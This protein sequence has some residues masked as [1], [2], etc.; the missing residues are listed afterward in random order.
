MR[1]RTNVI[2]GGFFWLAITF[3][4]LGIG[5][6][7]TAQTLTDPMPSARV[8]TPL[9]SGIVQNTGDTAQA[10][11]VT[12]VHVADAPWVRLNFDEVVL[13]GSPLHGTASH[14]I[15]TSL[16][17]GATQ[18]M[19]AEHLRQWQNT[20]AY[21][22][23]DTVRVELIAFPRNGFNRVRISETTVG[24]PDAGPRSICGSVDDRVLSFSDRV[25]RVSPVGCTAWLID[26]A[27]HCFLTAG[28]CTGGSLQVC[29]FNVPLANPNGTFNFPPPEDQYS[30]DPASV[31]TNGGLGIGNDWAYF[32]CF[33]NSNTGLTPFQAQGDFYTLAA[34]PPPVAGQTIRITG[35][36]TTTSPVSPTW[37]R[38]QKTHTGPYASFSGTTVQYTVDTTGGNS[39]SAVFNENTSE[40]IGIHTHGGCNTDGGNW[41]TGINHSGLQN[42]LANPQG[43]CVPMFPEFF[44]PNGLPEV[45]DPAG[46]TT[47]RVEVHPLGPVNPEPGTGQFHYDDGS[48]L[49]SIPMQEITPNVYDAVFPA[50][51][52]ESVVAY[53]F[54][55]QTTAGEGFTDPGNAP[56]STFSALSAVSVT[57]IAQFDFELAPGWT[58]ENVAVTGGAWDRGVPVGGGDRLDPPTDFDG[59]GQCFLTQNMDGNSDVDGGPTRLIS[60]VFDLTGTVNPSLSYARWFANDDLDIDRL[61]VEISDDDGGTWASIESVPHTEGWVQQTVRILDFVSLTDQV[62]VRFSAADNP[63]NSLTESAVD[64]FS[65]IDIAC[66]AVVAC[67]KGD[68][69]DDTF[70]NGGDIELFTSTMIGGGTPGTVVYC[71]VD[72]DDDGT[73]EIGDDLSLF[74]A[75]LL[76]EPCP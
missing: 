33:E 10:V 65:I 50:F 72:M 29:L 28:H 51:V 11:F 15:I 26:D 45:I 27:N 14:L 47:I 36:G 76:G 57:T 6:L 61:D 59:S 4:V 31:Q 2:Q 62:K 32:G 55:A 13:A 8:A 25:A 41:G 34:T 75:C 35:H 53:Y 1:A 42:A 73:L 68:V 19:N 9:D 48:G 64:A 71:S 58:V 3:S 63:N 69:N 20:S 7:V 17:D 38:V 66:G 24:A 52:C 18:F 56:T 39:G 44:Y 49:V 54:S 70:I 37:N 5:R 43:V 12:T 40:A 21:F 46:G 30:V 67:T 60:P 22:N 74:V 23:G 16:K